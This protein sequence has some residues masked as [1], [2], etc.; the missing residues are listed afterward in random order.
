MKL[1]KCICKPLSDDFILMLKHLNT[2]A[3]DQKMLLI[4]FLKY[5]GLKGGSQFGN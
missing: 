5:I 4:A 1:F 2:L 3:K